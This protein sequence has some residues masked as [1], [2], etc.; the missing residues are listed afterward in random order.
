MD[1]ADAVTRRVGASQLLWID[2]T[3]ALAAEAVDELD[4]RFELGVSTS[5]ALTALGSRAHIVVHGGH[6]QLRVLG[7]PGDAAGKLQWIEIVIAPNLIV[8]AHDGPAHF[9]DRLDDRIKS[10]A[11]VGNLTSASFLR[12]LLDA[13]ITTYHEAVDQIVDEV[14]ELDAR[15]LLARPDDDILPDLVEVRR[16]IS[17]LRRVLSDHREV[18]AALGDADVTDLAGADDEGFG[19][20]A[21]RFEDAIHSV[22]DSRDV[23][24]GSFEIFS[25][26]LAQ[27]TNEAM[28]VLALAT[29][30]LLPGSLIA[31]LLGMNVVVPL[32]KDDSSSFWIVVVGI[33]VLAGLVLAIAWRLHWIRIR[34]SPSGATASQ[35]SR[36]TSAGQMR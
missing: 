31:G 33:V 5:R 4:K 35:G 34:R 24:F 19:S 13:V 8:T 9:L 7:A 2:S 16:R 28:K 11:T 15:S 25:S 26:R 23:L 27:R 30:L 20:V 22:E 14:D 1:L 6:L 18:Y 12:S 17:R 3:S 10:D 21:A 29:V 32:S 36:R